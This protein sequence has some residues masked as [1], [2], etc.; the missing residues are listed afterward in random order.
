LIEKEAEMMAPKPSF[1]DDFL[2]GKHK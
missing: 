1:L 2:D